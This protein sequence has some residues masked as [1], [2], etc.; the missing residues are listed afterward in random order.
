MTEITSCSVLT[1][2]RQTTITKNESK[3]DEIK[4][5]AIKFDF[6]FERVESKKDLFTKS[7][8][9]TKWQNKKRWSINALLKTKSKDSTRTRPRTLAC[10]VMGLFRYWKKNIWKR[11]NDE[12]S[13]DEQ[14]GKVQREANQRDGG[15]ATVQRAKTEPG[16]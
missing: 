3:N 2:T 12:I 1:T 4:T 14:T 9:R 16:P 11:L 6:K 10:L 13:P 8:T 5:S 7:W 15:E